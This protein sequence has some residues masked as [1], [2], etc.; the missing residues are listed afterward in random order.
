MFP[1]LII[2]IIIQGAFNLIFFFFTLFFDC[3]GS[4]LQHM[5]F[6]CLWYVGFSCCGTQAVKCKGPVLAVNRLNLP[7]TCGTLIP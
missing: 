3:T 1:K 4:S 7:M 6:L 2:I 5:G